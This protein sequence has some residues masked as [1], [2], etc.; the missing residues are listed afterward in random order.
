MREQVS[1]KLHVFL[2]SQGH[3]TTIMSVLSFPSFLFYVYECSACMYVC[4]YACVPR[5]HGCQK[6]M[7][8]PLEPELQVVV[9]CLVGAGNLTYVL[10]KSP[11][12]LNHC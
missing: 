11:G 9:N 12:V 3:C 7:L 5:A 1:V 2:Y 8:A 10:C 4:M 6:K